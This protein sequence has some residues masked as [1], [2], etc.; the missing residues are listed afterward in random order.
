[1]TQIKALFIAPTYE[2]AAYWAGQRGFGTEDWAY[3]NVT[4]P[5]KLFG[6][7]APDY[8]AYICGSSGPD[9]PVWTEL[10]SRGFEVFAGEL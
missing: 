5:E 7:F 6:F 2:F 10:K 4:E 3:A 8:P 1:M 9:D